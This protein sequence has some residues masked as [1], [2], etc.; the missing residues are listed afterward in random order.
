MVA[1]NSPLFTL[2][3]DPAH[4]YYLKLNI[5]ER[6]KYYQI[7]ENHNSFYKALCKTM[8]T[9]SGEQ[10]V[11][12][13]AK[14]SLKAV[15]FCFQELN[16]STH[17]TEI[18][19][20]IEA[21]SKVLSFASVWS[22]IKF[23]GESGAELAKA[24]A[25]L[26]Q[27]IARRYF[28]LSKCDNQSPKTEEEDAFEKKVLQS[29]TIKVVLKG[30]LLLFSG[31]NLL[32]S[33]VKI[34]ESVVILPFQFL[35]IFLKFLS[36]VLTVWKLRYDGEKLWTHIKERRAVK[37]VEEQRG[38]VA[39]DP[40]KVDYVGLAKEVANGKVHHD[41]RSVALD[42]VYLAMTITSLTVV[43]LLGAVPPVLGTAFSILAFVT[44]LISFGNKIALNMANGTL[45]EVTDEKIRAQL[46]ALENTT[47]Q[48]EDNG[49]GVGTG[50]EEE[51]A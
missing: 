22:D 26:V 51:L 34:I 37:V 33:S 15:K 5:G 4:D 14:A 42:V 2:P 8:A 39:V 38:P 36:P 16:K 40:S 49:A 48:R 31:C 43:A 30:E 11:L 44:L 1:L 9:T 27:E 50:V 47:V 25:S 20:G 46:I 17:P 29:K 41:G 13:I 23:F 12:K 3:K 7:K 10:K 6:D 24:I 28:P 21:A 32:K 19:K 45:T 35:R 18:I